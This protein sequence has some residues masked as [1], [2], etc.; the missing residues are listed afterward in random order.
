MSNSSKSNIWFAIVNP[1]AG[2]GKTISEWQKAEIRLRA[3]KIKYTCA[4]TEYRRHALDLV[5]RAAAKGYRKF[6]AVGGDG[7]AHEVLNGIMRVY[8]KIGGRLEDFTLAVI[9]IG[10]GNDWIKAHKV[11]HD[12]EAV[13]DL[14][15]ARSFRTQDVVKVTQLNPDDYEAEEVRHDYMLNVGGVGFDARVCERV[16]AQ[17][18]NG[19]GGKL[20]YVRAL[21]NVLLNSYSFPV[22]VVADDGTAYE[23]DCYS[24]ALGIGPFSGGGMRQV[25]A[26]CLDDGLLDITVIPKMPILKLAAQLPKLFNGKL[27][28]VQELIM[29]QCRSILVLPIADLVEPI[30]IDGEVVGHFPARFEVIPDSITVLTNNLK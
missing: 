15:A 21:I 3:K 1:H 12:T 13:V 30:E 8:E 9:P 25:P 6:V 18:A 24:M 5:E 7:T 2:A 29:R 4:M 14:M 11:P 17:K 23:G 26:A 16:N 19:H 10:S 20:L 28:E 22:R 27:G